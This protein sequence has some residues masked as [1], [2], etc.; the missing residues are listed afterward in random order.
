M[1]PITAKSEILLNYE[2]EMS[3]KI[4]PGYILYFLFHTKFTSGL[5]SKSEFS[6]GV[7]VILGRKINSKILQ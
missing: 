6:L 7:D 2:V 3:I 1:L 4:G 5:C